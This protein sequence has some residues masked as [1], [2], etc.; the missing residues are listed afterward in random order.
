MNAHALGLFGLIMGVVVLVATSKL[1]HINTWELLYMA[2][3]FGLLIVSIYQ[4][5]QP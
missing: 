4:R 3:L 5:K 1:L 2:G